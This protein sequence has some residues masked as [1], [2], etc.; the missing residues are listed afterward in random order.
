MPILKLAVTFRNPYTKYCNKHYCGKS[1]RTI[2]TSGFRPSDQQPSTTSKDEYQ[3]LFDA[4]TV[5]M[6]K[7]II[8]QPPPSESSIHQ[9]AAEKDKVMSDWPK[10]ARVPN[11][12]HEKDRE[13]SAAA[14]VSAVVA[15][16]DK[17]S[18]DSEPSSNDENPC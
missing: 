11:Q 13:A 9:P 17:S 2:P 18:S 16:H 8:T 4:S 10:R 7:N 1:G 15:H 5:L 12:W 3:S 6:P 14:M